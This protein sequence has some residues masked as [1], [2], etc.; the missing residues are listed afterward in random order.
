MKKAI[1][2]LLIFAIAA[3]LVYAANFP[4]YTDKYVNDFAKVLSGNQSVELRALFSNVDSVTTAEVV[5][6]SVQNC[7]PLTPS[8]YAIQLLNQWGIGKKDKNNG[9]LILYCSQENKIF[10][11]TG[12]GLEG[13]LP[14]SKIGRLLDENYVPLRDSGNVASG[15][16]QFSQAISNVVIDNKDEVISEDSRN[17]NFVWIAV[18]LFILFFIFIFVLISRLKKLQKPK[19]AKNTKE[20]TGIKRTNWIADVI[21]TVFL[22]GI[23][24]A[25]GNFIIGFI[26]FLIVR[27][28]AAAIFGVRCSRDNL[29]MKKIKKEN[30][31]TYYQCPNGH[32]GKIAAAAAAGYFIGRGFAGG[33]GGFSGGGFGG[34]MGGGGGAGR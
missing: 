31:Y 24:F 11:A 28:I 30:G 12:Y 29:R 9:L 21:A 6:V 14:D 27:P 3:N 20:T 26:V 2:L 32:V 19:T 10:A 15:I 8:D 17:N 1:L 7:T 4:T 33:G 25:T 23:G 16:V 18:V 5:F 13:I 34:G 22:I